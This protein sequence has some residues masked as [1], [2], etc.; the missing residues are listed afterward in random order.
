MPHGPSFICAPAEQSKP[1]CRLLSNIYLNRYAQCESRSDDTV[2]NGRWFSS[3]QEF[4]PNNAKSTLVVGD[5]AR[6]KAQGLNLPNMEG[7]KFIDLHALT[8]EVLQDQKPDIILSPLVSEDFDAVDVAGVL[9]ALAYDGPYRAV[10][11]TLPDPEII[12]KEVR[13]HAPYLDFDLVV[14]PMLAPQN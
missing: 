11:N 5:M 12:R 10:T 4:I 2:F 1:P 6:W 14:L 3:L 8:V 7:L 9:S 13:N